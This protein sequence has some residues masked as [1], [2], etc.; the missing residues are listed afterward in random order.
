MK[1]WYKVTKQILLIAIIILFVLML[2]LLGIT[3]VDQNTVWYST[4][5]LPSIKPPG[6]VFAIIWPILY[7]M[8][9]ISVVLI[10]DTPKKKKTHKTIAI[11]LFIINGIL[12]ALYSILFFGMRSISLAFMEQL[13]LIASTLILVWCVYRL[14]KTAAYLLVPYLIWICF[15]TVLTGITLF[16]N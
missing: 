16:I 13:L 15:A 7:T 14:N 5:N 3:T 12:N 1:T 8:I 2:L 9:A 6:W 4:L 10:L 11:G